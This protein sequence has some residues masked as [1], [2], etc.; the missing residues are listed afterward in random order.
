MELFNERD[1]SL[2]LSIPGRAMNDD[3][4][5]WSKEKLGNYSVKSAYSLIQENKP[6]YHTSENYG[7]WRNL[8]NLKVPQKVKHFFW[9][10]ATNSLPSKTQLRSR[11]VDVN[12]L[13][14]ICNLAPETIMH[15]LVECQF[16]RDCLNT[17]LQQNNMQEDDSYITWLKNVFDSCNANMIG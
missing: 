17:K 16:A 12:V 1:A 6:A 13:C 10:A 5:Y 3:S 9:R 11:R 8:W 15:S 4:W 2:I 14:P 7:F